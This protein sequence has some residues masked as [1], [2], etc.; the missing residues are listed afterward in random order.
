MISILEP[1]HRVFITENC[2]EDETTI[3]YLKRALGK[4][5]FPKENVIEEVDFDVARN[6]DY[7]VRCIGGTIQVFTL[8]FILNFGFVTKRIGEL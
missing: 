7:L 6:G 3:K 4:Y 8:E 2:L 1:S 5:K